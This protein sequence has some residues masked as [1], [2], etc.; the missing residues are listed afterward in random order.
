MPHYYKHS[1]C[2]TKLTYEQLQAALL[3][4]RLGEMKPQC[5]AIRFGIPSR[6]LYDHMHAKSKK[7]YGGCPEGG[8]IAIVCQVQ[9][10][11]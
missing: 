5:A 1:G 7:R 10:Q 11:W 3:A 8:E 9:F 6:T 2:K 4:I